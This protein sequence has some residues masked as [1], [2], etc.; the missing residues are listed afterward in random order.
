MSY[1]FIYSKASCI[2]FSFLLLFS[3]AGAANTTFSCG[4]LDFAGETYTLNQ[5]VSVN[6]ATCL[7]VA[8]P[9]I[10]LDCAGFSITGNNA[11]G[12]A[13][14]YSNSSGTIVRNCNIS[15]FQYGVYFN[16]TAG[17]TVEGT[18]ATTSRAGGVGIVLQDSDF[19]TIS[20]SLG[21]T[22]G[23]QSGGGNASGGSSPAAGM[24]LISSS[25]NTISGSIAFSSKYI[26]LLVNSNCHGNVISNLNATTQINSATACAGG[27]C[28]AIQI[29]QDNNYNQFKNVIA[30]AT[31]AGCAVRINQGD[32]NIF[33]N[34]TAQSGSSFA[35]CF[36]TG[37]SNSVIANSTFLSTGGASTL[38]LLSTGSIGN[39]FY[40][41]NFTQT[42][43]LYVNDSSGSN[44]FNATINGNPEGN[45]W[46]NVMNGSVNI[47]GTSISSGF[48][49]LYR[50]ATGAGYPYNSTNSQ[51]KLSGAVA[52]YAPLTPYQEPT[53]QAPSIS[54]NLPAS[55]TAQSTRTISVNL[56][57]SDAALN[58][59]S[60]FIISEQGAVVNSTNSSAIGNY[61]VQLGVPSDGIYGINATAYGNSSLSN[62]SSVSN[63]TVDSAGPAISLSYPANWANI[64]NHNLTFLWVPTDALGAAIACNLS[65]NGAVNASGIIGSSGSSFS[66]TASLS[67]GAYNWSVDCWDGL[68]NTNSSQNSYFTIISSVQ[69]NSSSVNATGLPS[70]NVTINGTEAVSGANYTGNLTVNMS[71]GGSTVVAFNFNF[72]YPLNLSA[73]VI[74]NGTNAGASYISVN[75]VNST[76]G[77]SGT[78]TVYLYGA[79]SSYNAVCVKEMEG[80]GYQNIS[81]DCAGANEYKVRCDG[82]STSGTFAICTSPSSGVLRVSGLLHSSLQ[83]YN[84][85]SQTTQTGS[86]S[87]SSSGGGSSSGSGNTASYQKT[88]EYLVDIGLNKTCKIS[89]KRELA[90]STNISMLTT[91]LENLGGSECNLE[92]FV[93]EDTVPDSFAAI[94]TINFTPM[95]SSREGWKIAFKFPRFSSGES[96]AITYLVAGWVPPS[97]AGNFTNSVLTAKK[98]VAPAP[99]KEESPAKKEEKNQSFPPSQQ[100][101]LQPM[102][103]TSGSDSRQLEA[104]AAEKE[105]LKSKL[106]PVALI[107]LAV[108]S[109]IAIVA[110]AVYFLLMRRRRGL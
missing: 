19:N 21:S 71:S 52:D 77:L 104:D 78:K 75:G 7:S 88:A 33:N 107:S 28:G 41:N 10:T 17:G 24:R 36:Y 43:G 48:S 35:M 20:N 5:S 13:G 73:I 59:T 97:R 94:N 87:S 92:E 31:S 46:A 80:I 2:I 95:Y 105:D 109:G 82:S 53:Q 37:A 99:K 63:I 27:P 61:A 3:F 8:A 18:N 39:T 14:V 1:S 51:G 38:V 50:G 65:I 4:T 83:Q 45:I 25:N 58:Y 56:T 66:A 96:K 30:T 102:Q 54:L 40:W 49:G 34:I 89:V 91:T 57:V 101:S 76:G 23:S 108:L 22:Y 69:G 11:T 85:V 79:S 60:I 72:S 29:G 98:Q 106:V 74:A 103:V 93:F 81:S 86:G 12:T 70:L 9:N 67:D 68:N 90:S 16:G 15:N 26:G 100:P 64:T 62:S 55:N 84:I 32:S 42:S 47:T 44:Y 110:V 6:G